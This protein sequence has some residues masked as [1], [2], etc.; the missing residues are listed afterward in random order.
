MRRAADQAQGAVATGQPK[1]ARGYGEV[2]GKRIEVSVSYAG[3]L[4]LEEAVSRY[5]AVRENAHALG[6]ARQ[7]DR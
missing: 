6:A 1:P 3:E 4:G 2:A 5:L 7:D